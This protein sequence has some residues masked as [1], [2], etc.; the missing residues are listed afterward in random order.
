MKRFTTLIV[1]MKRQAKTTMSYHY[2]SIR[3]TKIKILK[4][5]NADKNSHI[6]AGG[7]AIWYRHSSSFLP[8]THTLS[9]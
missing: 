7:N 4:I 6:I 3:I 5:A 9:I 1:I 8:V 2:T